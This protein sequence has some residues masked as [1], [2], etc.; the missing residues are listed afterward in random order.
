VIVPRRLQSLPMSTRVQT[1]TSP[2]LEGPIATL[3]DVTASRMS[4][5]LEAELAQRVRDIAA[6][7]GLSVSAWIAEAIRQGVRH[8]GLGEVIDEIIAE[9]GWDRDD[10]IAEAQRSHYEQRFP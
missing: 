8:V 10:L 4:V 3:H 5:S 7:Q 2:P 9:H 6:Q 1:K